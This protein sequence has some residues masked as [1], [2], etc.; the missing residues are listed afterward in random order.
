MTT[1]FTNALDRFVALASAM[2]ADHFERNFPSLTPPRFRYEA[3][4]KYV[5][6]VRADA[7]GSGQRSVH[8]FVRIADGA[9][10]KAAGW[11]APFIAKGGPECPATVRGNIFASDGGQDCLTVYGVKDAR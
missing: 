9:V 5:R 1:E 3:G 7:I 11:K 6:I 2:S 8:C 10:L 4:P